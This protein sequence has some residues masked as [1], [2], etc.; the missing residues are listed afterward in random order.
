MKNMNENGYFALLLE[1]SLRTYFASQGANPEALREV[2]RRAGLRVA[3]AK[4]E[5]EKLAWMEIC[6]IIDRQ[7]TPEKNHKCYSNT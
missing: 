2:Q 3:A 5:F 6:T 1:E 7:L 4:T